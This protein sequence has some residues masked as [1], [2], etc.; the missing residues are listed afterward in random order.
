MRVNIIIIFAF[1]LFLANFSVA[2]EEQTDPY[3]FDPND[4]SSF[5]YSNG[6]Y[7]TIADWSIVD[8]NKIPPH[9]I[10]EVP[11][12]NLDYAKV[13][14]E[15][16]LQMTVDQ[17]AHN[18]EVIENLAIDVD[19]EKAREAIKK[20]YGVSV[21]GLDS[22]AKIE[23]NILK[24]D[25]G[26]FDFSGKTEQWEIEVNVY[27]E[28][29]V[30]KPR[31]VDEN[32]ISQQDDFTLTYSTEEFLTFEQTGIGPEFFQFTN[33]DGE[34][35]FL[36]NGMSFRKGQAH[37]K[38][39]ETITVQS[40]EIPSNVFYKISAVHNDI[41]VYFSRTGARESNYV[42]MYEDGLDI[43]TTNEGA[44]NVIPQPGNGLFNMVKREYEKD[45][46]GKPI[47]S[48]FRLVP[49]DRED[50]EITVSGGDGLNVRS[51]KDSG[52]VPLMVHKD[53]GGRTSIETG[54]MGLEIESGNL[55]VIPPQ[56]FPEDEREP[57]DTRNSVAFVLVPDPVSF[58]ENYELKTS[59]SN[60]FILSQDGKEVMGNNMGLEVSDEIEPNM[61]KTT[62]D[63]RVK[64]PE[65]DFKLN[66]SLEDENDGVIKVEGYTEITAN[67]AQATNQWLRDKPGIEK[68]VDNVDFD[69]RENALAKSKA[70]RVSRAY[71]VGL[72]GDVTVET[73]IVDEKE[74]T[75]GFGE[76][77]IDPAT[78]L[79]RPFRELESV[80]N[81][82]DHEF[83]HLLDANV[84]YKETPVLVS[85]AKNA[86][87]SERYNLFDSG[88]L[89]QKFKS[90]FE[91]ARISLGTF[92]SEYE[93]RQNQIIHPLLRDEQ[94]KSTLKEMS[95]YWGGG[96]NLASA[97]ERE[98]TPQ[99]ISD[100]EVLLRA[101]SSPEAQ[102]LWKKWN[103][104]I[105]DK[106][107]LYPYS[108]DERE[109]SSTYSELP[110]RAQR[111]R[112]QP[113]LAQLEFDRAASISPPPQWLYDQAA[114]RCQSIVGKECQPCVI[115][116]LTCKR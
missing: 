3:T 2:Q 52:L 92:E 73:N 58:G 54:R 64:Y 42:A 113:G 9:R 63:L 105:A 29:N 104:A 77:A 107:G 94:V 68:F 19:E 20:T 108:F 81:I 84:Q 79:A 55:Q 21:A 57:I 96:E 5:D 10:P 49:D 85:S 87:E 16:R 12:E 100:I 1:V 15:Q 72:V 70:Q 32:T 22:Q 30:L 114:K 86:V 106:T 75:M 28:V 99:G 33:K 66:P 116:T 62:D 13:N 95:D 50:T 37:I 65:I 60:R 25:K 103:L 71:T 82:F 17:I 8:W 112:K 46:Q 101:D 39:G 67:M 53:G 4:P 41:N 74:V 34:R 6:D 26:L 11:V 44:L 36:E 90:S 83:V 48:K 109:L 110:S 91:S 115:Y 97:L 38:K 93:S 80:L 51:R 61:V 31:A 43:G 78:Q 98:K 23:N 76:R 45:A 35:F 7:S 59:S 88:V 111:A 24:S 89:D 56:P 18:L 40:T 14:T 47:L 102:E 27:G 69:L